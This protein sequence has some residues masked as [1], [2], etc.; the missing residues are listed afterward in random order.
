MKK[1]NE[2]V[3]LITFVLVWRTALKFDVVSYMLF[4]RQDTTVD[5]W[6]ESWFCPLCSRFMCSASVVSTSSLFFMS[7]RS[8]FTSPIK[9]CICGATVCSSNNDVFLVTSK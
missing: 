4:W 5:A 8:V 3:K 2:Y 6:S 9:R 7:F 1:K